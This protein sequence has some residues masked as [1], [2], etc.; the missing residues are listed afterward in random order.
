M[1]HQNPSPNDAKTVLAGATVDH[2]SSRNQKKVMLDTEMTKKKHHTLK[3][4]RNDKPR[5]TNDSDVGRMIEKVRGRQQAPKGDRMG[6]LE[7]NVSI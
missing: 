7:T 3:T 5:K 1:F 4:E 2:F 6:G